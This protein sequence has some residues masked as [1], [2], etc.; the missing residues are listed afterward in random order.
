M[1][2]LPVLID[3]DGMPCLV[4]GGGPIALHKA[5][6]LLE[7]GADVTVVAP[8]ILPEISEL[9][10]KTINRRVTEE[11]CEGRFL[12][13]DATGDRAAEKLLSAA[14]AKMHVPYICAGNG[15]LCTAMLPAVYSS[16]RTVV[17]VSSKGASPAASAWLRNYLAEKV[18][19]NMDAVLDRMSDVRAAAKERLD[20]QP[21]R[22]VFMRGCLEKMLKTGDILSDADINEMLDGYLKEGSK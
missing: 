11:D 4:A 12:V 6:K 5:E 15:D 3:M 10:V 2:F 22:R 18:P 14:C 21:E 8:V 20:S 9:P 13:A 16:G 17:A 19:E 1:A 7:H